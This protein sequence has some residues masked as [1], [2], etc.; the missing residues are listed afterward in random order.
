MRNE[1]RFCLKQMG[2]PHGEEEESA[3]AARAGLVALRGSLTVASSHKLADAIGPE[4]REDARRLAERM[5][6]EKDGGAA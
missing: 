3:F 2:G 1:S 5:L 6:R 4:T